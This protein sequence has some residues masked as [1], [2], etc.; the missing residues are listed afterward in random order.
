MGGV[1]GVCG[2]SVWCVREGTST[3]S[4]IK[5]DQLRHELQHMYCA[6]Y[7]TTAIYLIKYLQQSL[8]DH[9]LLSGWLYRFINNQCKTSTPYTLGKEHVHCQCEEITAPTQTNT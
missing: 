2:G 4:N 7:T 1:C 5:V 6:C 9:Y 3:C 8:W